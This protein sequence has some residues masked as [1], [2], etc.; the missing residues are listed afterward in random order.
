MLFIVRC[1]VVVSA[2]QMIKQEKHYNLT[3]WTT[4]P[5]HATNHRMKA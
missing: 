5:A 2:L 3:T 1:F 4:R